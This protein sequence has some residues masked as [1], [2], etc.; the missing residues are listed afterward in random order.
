MVA[1]F[2]GRWRARWAGPVL[3]VTIVGGY[4][5]FARRWIRRVLSLL[6][7]VLGAVLLVTVLPGAAMADTGPCGSGSNAITCEN[8]QPGTPLANWY[9]PG[10]WGDIEAFPR[11]TS[12]QVGGTINFSVSSPVP[13]TVAIYRLGWYGGD[14]ARL[15][16][17]SPTATYPAVTQPACDTAASTGEVDCG[18][19]SVTD[20]WSVP[21]SAVSGV[22]L[23][24]FD[25]SDGQGLM[26]YPFVVT[27]PSSTSDIV[28]QTSDQTWQ[29]YNMWGGDDLYQGD[30]PAPDGR[31][32]AVSYN[33]P[34]DIAGENGIYGSEYPMIQFMERNGYDV[35]Y[36]SSVDITQNPALLLNHKVYVSSGHDEYWDQQQWNAVTAA[37]DAGVNL[38]FFSGN[39]V[40]WRT[41]LQPSIA[42]GT[43]ERTVTSYKMT[44]MEL[45]TAGRH[46]GPE[47]A[48]DRD[49][50]GSRWQPESVEGTPGNQLTGTLFT[51]NGYRDD[52]ITV[53]Y[54]YS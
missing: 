29:A 2:Y 42:D 31:A 15:M 25:Q 46:R 40:F 45:P 41:E 53:T 10:S 1:A 16:P 3:G 32:Y 24:E 54:P 30:G 5:A 22:Y 4:G 39:E 47:R 21:S 35:S 49:L 12:V 6:P 52:A 28:V 26:P 14:G 34:M 36:V 37:K 18:N 19:W 38:A 43:P 13:F 48:V 44:K 7:I 51:V 50:D 23:A 33:R 11:T 17:S 27:N 20:S 8:S 9:S